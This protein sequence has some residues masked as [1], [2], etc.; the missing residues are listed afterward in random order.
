MQG[1]PAFA[2]SLAQVAG[3]AMAYAFDAAKFFPVDVNEFAGFVAFIVDDR[4]LGLEAGAELLSRRIRTLPA[5]KRA[6]NL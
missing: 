4:R 3:N 6:S 1:F 2:A 5:L